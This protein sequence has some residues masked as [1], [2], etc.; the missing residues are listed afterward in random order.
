MTQSH[1]SKMSVL[2]ITIPQSLMNHEVML[3]FL[4]DTL[5]RKI[6]IRIIPK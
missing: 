1:E 2:K 3:D 5:L 6:M 4:G